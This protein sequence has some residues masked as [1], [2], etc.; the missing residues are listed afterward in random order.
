MA[1]LLRN[2]MFHEQS[3]GYPSSQSKAASPPCKKKAEN[4]KIKKKRQSICRTL[5]IIT[6]PVNPLNQRSQQRIYPTPVQEK[7]FSLEICYS[8]RSCLCSIHCRSTQ[9]FRCNHQVRRFKA[10]PSGTDANSQH[11]RKGKGR[12]G[13]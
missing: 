3:K 11:G 4:Y 2:N 5:N 13:R 10:L 1:S 9:K 6:T 8:R 12:S 7:S